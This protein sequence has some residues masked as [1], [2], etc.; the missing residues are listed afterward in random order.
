MTNSSVDADD[1]LAVAFSLHANPGAYAL[2]LG[3]GVSAPSGIPTAWGVLEDLV[4]RVAEVRGA[5]PD[6][7][8]AWYEQQ[9]GE[10]P[11]YEGV[12]ERVAPTQIE[13]QRLL[14]NYFEQRPEDMETGRKAPT[15][16]H[17]SIARLVR[18]EAVKVIVT[19]NFDHLIERAL[20]DEGISP[21]VVA[22]P[23]EV[24]GMAPLHTLNCCIIHLHGDYLNPTSMLN[25]VT[26]L[27]AY[28]P[29]TSKLLQMILENYG[30]ILAGWSSKYDPALRDAIAAHYPNRFTLTW[31]EPGPVSDEA[32]NLRTLKKGVLVAEDADTGFGRIA[33]GVEALASRRA[34][35][36]LTVPVA[37]ET[38]KREL[39]GRKVAI[40]LHDTLR[41][42]FAALHRV[43]E[44]NLATYQ[45]GGDYETMLGRVEETSRMAGALVAT[46]AYW[47]DERTDNWWIDELPRF[48]TPVDGSGL[49]RLLS[50]RVI[51]GSILFYAAGVSAVAGQRFDLL[52]RL[53]A[54]QRPN[55]YS[56]EYEPLAFSLDAGSGY[57]N[58]RNSPTRV[59]DTVVP[60]L[61]EA[62]SFGS[63][64]LDDSWQLFE[65]LRL[66]W[67]THRN[68]QFAQLLPSYVEMDAAY[69]EANSALERAGSGNGEAQRARASVQQGRDRALEVLG[70]LAPVGRPH[71]LT[72]DLRGNERYRSVTANRLISDIKA[73]GTA[74]P[75]IASGF[76]TDPDGFAVA[77]AAVSAR[78]GTIGSDLSWG[79]G[80]GFI[81]SQIW[82]DTGKTP[83]ELRAAAAPTS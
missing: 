15:A 73:E 75:L 62:L 9:F 59:F 81:P 53:F 6:D 79:R 74:H 46:L 49:V 60:L 83:E 63:E 8:I 35:H 36:P 58:A 26:E 3:A 10:Y 65:V 43:P 68:P 11:T 55:R 20:L 45:V 1:L 72:T 23:S 57:E 39:S 48:A 47:G 16:A 41:R 32:A 50:L 29:S 52:A 78:L 80:N 69:Q 76:N 67:V 12:L 51:T 5:T 61:K 42:E 2:L 22:S 82:L 27:A 30:L 13:R 33:D 28:H 34:R 64:A 14:R 40:G 37:V 56:G 18:S 25:T 70:R 54:L 21:T 38:A 66:A 17:R 19:L 4:T 44:F 71:V 7:V 31:F 24:E 77:V